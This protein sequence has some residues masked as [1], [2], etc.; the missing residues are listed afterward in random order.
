MGERGLALQKREECGAEPIQVDTF[1]GR[2][3]I[4]WDTDSSATPIGQLAFFADFL[5]NAG[6][7]DDWVGDCPLSCTRPNAPT[8]RD[9]LGMWMLSVLA[10]H[11]RYAHVTALRG[12]G[13]GPQVLWMRRIVS[14]DA[15]RRMLGLI[16][17]ETGAAWMRRHLM[18]SIA[19]ALSEPWILDVDTTIKTLYGRQEG[20]EIGPDGSAWQS[21]P[22]VPDA[23]ARCRTRGR[24]DDQY[25]PSGSMH[26]RG[27]D[28]SGS[29]LSRSRRPRW[30]GRSFPAS[31][32]DRV[33]PGGRRDTIR[34]CGDCPARSTGRTPSR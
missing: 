2:L 4:E 21:E 23:D 8:N 9:I 15:L 19:P 26:N 11:K 33:S 24:R 10:C 31:S 5:K 27:P 30:I 29:L 16:D 3:H 22:S 1:G 6:V 34:W 20:A 13:V 25:D 14:K 17:E 18:R 7:F 28:K 12:D 32:R